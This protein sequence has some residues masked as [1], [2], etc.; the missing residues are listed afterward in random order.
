M[1]LPNHE[2]GRFSWATFDVRDLLPD[3]WQSQALGVAR[4]C[5]RRKELTPRSVTSRESASVQSI[6]VATVPGSDV[7]AKLPWLW[8]LYH[9]AFRELAQS[10]SAEPV[11][12]ARDDRIKINL[13]VQLGAEMRYECHGRLQ[14]D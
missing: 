6:S 5:M 13:N 3:D 2:H 14:S 9:S 8:E 11:Q 7:A 1:A 12:I 4:E 10:V